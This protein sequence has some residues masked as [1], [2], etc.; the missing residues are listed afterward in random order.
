[1]QAADREI[2]RQTA[3]RA[4]AVAEFAAARPASVDRQPGQPG[5]MSA[6]RRAARPEVLAGVSEWAAQELVVALSISSA[7]AE[8]LLTRSLTLVHRLPA[9]LSAL[10][11][12]ALHCGHLWPMLEKVAQIAD[13]K[14]RRQV[15]AGL[16]GWAAGRVTT[17]AQL[18]AKARRMVL[19]SDARGAGQ[20][21][22]A[23]LRR[24]G[25]SLR[26]D[27]TD[28]LATVTALVTVPEAQALVDTLGRYADAL[29][30]EPGQPTRTR[31]QKMVDCLLD[32][33]LRPGETD[34]PPVQAQ[35]TLVAPVSTLAGGDQPG[36]IGGQPVPAEMI[37]SLARAFGLLPDPADDPDT[38]SPDTDSPDPAAVREAEERWW[39]EVEQ[40]VLAEEWGGAEAAPDDE[41]IRYWT[42][43]STAAGPDEMEYRHRAPEP[44]VGIPN[45]EDGAPDPEPSP[46]SWAA[47]DAAVNELSGALWEVDVALGR[48]R[49]AVER[50]EIADAADEADWQQSSAG[51]VSAADDVIAAL[52][53]VSADR[54]AAL[55]GLLD[56]TAGGRLVDRPRIAV[57]DALTGT[58]LA[59]TDSRELR[60]RSACAASACHRD[61][62]RCT[63]DL[64]GLPGLGPP[65]DTPG[66]RPGA[67]LD[68][69]VRARDRR[70]RF[71]GCRNRV[72]RGGE[73]DHDRPWPDGPTSAGNLTGYCTSHHRGKH[74]APGW[75]YDLAP[76]GTLTVTTP[77]GLVATTTPAPY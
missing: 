60:R 71:P 27:D 11:A 12:G 13:P 21:L 17:P 19:A 74:Q 10:E 46:G 61:P 34:L 36:E 35:W 6:E 4:R 18:G 50:A 16:L 53:H 52:A 69:Y 3:L 47:A 1:M 2:A 40:R 44:E 76:D 73:L 28:G 63:H 37:R 51:R 20:R 31:G 64:D 42:H 48:A 58:L 5:C 59:L 75:Q 15:E 65:P 22:T 25:V 41:L 29:D 49:R 9:T 33:V 67:A 8:A 77:T 56:A 62:A 23:A 30:E 24:R 66:Y 32:L 43:Q 70:C 72:P 55:A 57:T 7:A 39:A 54:R 38:D 14:V 68:R 45:P 26:P